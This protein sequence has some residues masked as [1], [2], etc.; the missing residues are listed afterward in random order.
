MAGECEN[1]PTDLAH[2]KGLRV[3]DLVAKVAGVNVKDTAR[4]LLAADMVAWL[5]EMN[6]AELSLIP[7][8]VDRPTR[9]NANKCEEAFSL[10]MRLLSQ[11]KD[12]GLV[13]LKRI[14]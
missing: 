3:H 2:L 14:K 7:F 8:S 10:L 5:L 1:L 11:R 13:A 4:V 9:L 6:N 12:K